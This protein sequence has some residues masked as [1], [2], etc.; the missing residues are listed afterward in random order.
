MKRDRSS[1]DNLTRYEK[2][3]LSRPDITFEELFMF[4]FDGLTVN[5]TI[6]INTDLTESEKYCVLAEELAHYDNDVGDITDQSIVK[7]RQCE[8]RSRRKALNMICSPKDLERAFNHGCRNR[9]EIAEYLDLPEQIIEFAFN[10]Y[11]QKGVISLK[12]ESE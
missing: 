3:L 11:I 12:T 5:N 2:L 4:N 8:L 1:T 9:F 7:N 10:T 6:Y